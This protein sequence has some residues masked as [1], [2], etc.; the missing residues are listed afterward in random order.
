MKLAW[1]FHFPDNTGM[2]QIICTCVLLITTFLYAQL[3]SDYLLCNIIL[4]MPISPEMQ[5]LQLL[6][7]FVNFTLGGCGG[8]V[9][10]GFASVLLWEDA[11]ILKGLILI[12]FNFE[13]VWCCWDD[14]FSTIFTL[15]GCGG[16]GRLILDYLLIWICLITTFSIV[17]CLC[18][19]MCVSVDCHSGQNVWL[20]WLMASSANAV[21]LCHHHCQCWHHCHVYST[22]YHVVDSS[23][24]IWCAF[25]SI[26]L[27]LMC[28]D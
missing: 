10:T 11:V 18:V 24:L 27:S 17:N 2:S 28:I 25:I 21:G 8:L 14:S 6:K 3:P 12:S 26:L 19:F 20:N 22:A 15:G 23:E 13:K 1:E 9:R 16:L 4:S 5:H 7:Y